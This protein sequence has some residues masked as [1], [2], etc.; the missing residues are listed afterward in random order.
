VITTPEPVTRRLAVTLVIAA[1]R[2][3]A[4]TVRAL[5][6][7]ADPDESA[8]LVYST[9]TLARTLAA[10]LRTSQGMLAAD[11]WLCECA[12]DHPYRDTRLGAALILAHTMTAETASA[13]ETFD[14]LC[15]IGVG[16]YNEVCCEADDRFV[17]VLTA[18]MLCLHSLLPEAGTA[19][20]PCMV[21]N[22]AIT[23]WGSGAEPEGKPM[24]RARTPA[25]DSPPQPTLAIPPEAEVAGGPAPW[26][27]Q[28]AVPPGA[29]I[30]LR[31]AAIRRQQQS[32]LW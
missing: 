6:Y 27:Y 24:F 12:R 21:G 17:D 20:G 4:G 9:L 31:G 5:L 30:S 22:T 28:V 10:S 7:A 18:A 1:M 2:G 14:E 3:D 29:A 26:P 25:E 13:G 8:V 16:A 32:G 19:A 11:L 23:L 15:E